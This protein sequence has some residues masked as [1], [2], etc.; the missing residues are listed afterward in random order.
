MATRRSR[1]AWE[2]RLEQS[3]RAWRGP[4]AGF[5]RCW[6]ATNCRWLTEVIKR[7]MEEEL[8]AY[9]D[10]E[11]PDARRAAVEAYL[12]EHPDDARRLEAYRADGKAIAR[13]FSRAGAA[14]PGTRPSSSS[15]WRS[16]PWRLAAAAVLILAVG[17]VAG[18]FGRERVNDTSMERLGHRAAA[19]HLI[20]NGPGVEPLA[21]SSLDELSRRMSSTLGIRVQLRDPSSTGYKIVG[22]RIVP[23][24]EG[25][26]VQLIVRGHDHV[27]HRGEARRQGNPL[28]PHRGRGLNHASVGRRRSRLRDYQRA[29]AE[30]TRRSRPAHLRRASGLSATR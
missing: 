16:V 23:Q 3:C 30:E 6:K 24:A 22:A 21:T 19:A 5:G 15:S 28:P 14:T 10:G 17:A 13:I 25:R 8:H 27:L 20:L 2:F 29:G 4:V 11:L 12:R 7:I 18:W 1:T 9:L 26:A